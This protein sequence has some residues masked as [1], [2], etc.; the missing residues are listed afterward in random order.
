MAAQVAWA[1]ALARIQVPADTAAELTA[2]GIDSPSSLAETTQSLVKSVCKSLREGGDAMPAM[3]EHRLQAMRIWAR[4]TTMHDQPHEPGLWVGDT[5]GKY[6]SYFNEIQERKDLD[7]DTKVKLPKP[8][9]VKTDYADFLK[10]LRNYLGTIYSVDQIATLDYL[11]RDDDNVMAPADLLLLSE[12][13]QLV[14][15]T[16]HAGSAF[17]RDKSELWTIVHKLTSGTPA[18]PYVASCQRQRDGREAVKQ[19][20]A[21]YEGESNVAARREEWYAKLEKLQYRGESQHFTFESYTNRHAEIH[22]R[23]TNLSEALSEPRK[24]IKFLAGITVSNMTAAC[25]QVRA[26]LTMRND[27]TLASDYLSGFIVKKPKRDPRHI[28]SATGSPPKKR[29]GNDHGKGH[30][31]RG[32]GK[33]ISWNNL[34]KKGEKGYP[35]IHAGS[36]SDIEWATL[37]GSDKAEVGKLRKTEEMRTVAAMVHKLTTADKPEEAAPVVAAAII[38]AGDMMKGPKNGKKV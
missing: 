27:F 20:K 18:W 9:D 11:V 15:G 25:A 34:P 32:G 26:D 22:E 16:H 6:V 8:W 31:G 36:Y 4:H 23:L 37:S 12:H 35:E 28:S 10:N 30:G 19:M 21:H 1:A 13:D 17:R 24:V 33:K 38:G 5:I 7:N 14:Q 2:E 29:R 3:S